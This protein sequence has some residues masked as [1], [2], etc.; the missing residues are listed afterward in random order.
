MELVRYPLKYCRI[1]AE[2]VVPTEVITKG[3]FPRYFSFSNSSLLMKTD[4]IFSVFTRIN[5]PCLFVL[6]YRTK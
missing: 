4:P 5:F 3:T 1:L 6:S 2:F